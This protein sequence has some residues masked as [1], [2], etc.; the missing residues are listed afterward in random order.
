MGK[1]NWQ[2]GSF[3]I[4]YTSWSKWRDLCGYFSQRL[5]LEV[6]GEFIPGAEGTKRVLVHY[7]ENGMLQWTN[8]I[9]SAEGIEPF[10]GMCY[11]SDG[12]LHLVGTYVGSVMFEERQDSKGQ[13]DIFVAQLDGNGQ[14]TDSLCR[15]SEDWAND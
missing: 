4:R 9:S 1:V 7:D 11:S 13:A 15:C 8:G 3:R 2:Y 10:G 14:F 5:L 12:Y 6:E